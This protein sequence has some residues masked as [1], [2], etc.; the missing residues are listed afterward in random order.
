MTIDH[1]KNFKELI[2]TFFLEFLE[3]F[4][5]QVASEI[6]PDSITFLQQEYFADLVEGEEKI[7]DL[8]VLVKRLGTDTTFIVHIEAQSNSQANFNRRLFFYFAIL[9]QRHLQPVYPIVVYSFDTPKRA[10]PDSYKVEFSDRKVLEFNFA[11]VQLNRLNWRD[12]IHQ[13]NPVAA[14]LMAK[15][16]IAKSDR[17]KVKAECLRLLVTLRLDPAKTRLVSKFIDTY[18]SLN[19]AEEQVFQAEVGKMEPVQKERIMETL[20]SWEKKGME[21]GIE[22]ATLTIALSLLE[23]NVPL[24]TIAQ[25]TKL[26]IAQLQQLQAQGQDSTES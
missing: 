24:E 13:S 26:T 14:A 19:G 8:L 23:Q 1:D 5:P 25:A 16:Q 9:H 10:E 22:K 7:V 6:D 4:L 18:L 20:T 12:Y 2:S 21:K 15:M 11:T 17:P 3:L